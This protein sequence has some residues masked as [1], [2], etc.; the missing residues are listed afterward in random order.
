M[1]HCIYLHL[2]K[3]YINFSVIMFVISFSR[4]NR[5]HKTP[6]FRAV[7]LYF[8]VTVEK[9]TKVLYEI[10]I[11]HFDSKADKTKNIMNNI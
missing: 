11:P 7:Q 6:D 10:S 8:A 9:A 2:N 3:I 5:I 4:L 1:I